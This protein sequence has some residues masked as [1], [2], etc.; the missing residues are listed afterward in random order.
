MRNDVAYHVN[1]DRITCLFY[2][3][4]AKLECLLDIGLNNALKIN[5]AM[6][7]RQECWSNDRTH[8]LVYRN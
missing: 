1:N 8:L 6:R 4:N 2:R 7:V 3:C 5:S